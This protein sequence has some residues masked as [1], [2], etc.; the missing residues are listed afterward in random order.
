MLEVIR[1]HDTF[2]QHVINIHFHCAPDQIL[3]DLINHALEGGPSIF[4]PAGH[5]HVAINF[6]TSSKSSLVFIWWVHLDLVVLGVGVHEAK[7]FMAYLCLYQLVD[8]WEGEA[9]L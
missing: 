8:L 9:I 4:K 5:H 6:P 1:A 7:K 3:E 2:H